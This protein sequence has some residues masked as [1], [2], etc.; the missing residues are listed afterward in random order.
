MGAV[1]ALMTLGHSLGMMSGALLAGVI[2]DLST[3]NNVFPLGAVVIAAGS[4]FCAVSIV[5]GG[6]GLK[7]A[8][9]GEQRVGR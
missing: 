3:V 2:M 9:G 4:V 1:M 8:K 7:Q 5:K 6:N